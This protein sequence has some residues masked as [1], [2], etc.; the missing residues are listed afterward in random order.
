MLALSHDEVVHG[1]G[2]LIDKM[3]GDWWQ[4]FASLRL[5][6]G[7]QYTHPGKKLLFMGQE[8]GQWAE[9]NEDRGLDWG[10]L[11][12][13]M[14]VQMQNWVRDLNLLYK[15]QPA[16]YQRDF[17]P[18][19][20]RWS[21]PNDAEQSVLTYLRFAENSADFLVVGCNFTPV[22]RYNYRIG[23]PAPGHYMEILNSDS[24]Y[25]GGSN[26]G[27]LGGLDA[28]PIEWHADR[29]SIGLTLP[30]LAVVILK[31][32]PNHLVP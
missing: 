19:G 29:Q 6:F 32:V 7:Y 13:P 27:N 9:W 1:K 15:A 2:S 17:D 16:L 30:P 20:F 28:E 5:L 12:W 24:A 18:T 8:F 26:I 25:Y 11:N 4:K 14:H 22:P 3:A 23:V 21:E 31:L 10:L